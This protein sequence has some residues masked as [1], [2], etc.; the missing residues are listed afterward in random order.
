M[1]DA[2]FAVSRRNLV[3]GAAAAAASAAFASGIGTA[4]ADEA[5]AANRVCQI[6]GIE[7]PVVQA[8]M[9]GLTSPELSAAVSEAGGL[10]VLELPT[11]ETIRATKALT[12]KPF[13]AAEYYYDDET[14]AML[15]EEGVDIVV[16]CSAAAIPCEANGY[17]HDYESISAYKQAGFT[18]IFKDLNATPE[19]TVAAVEAGADI[20]AVIGFG[21]GGSG[22]YV[23]ANTA[24]HIAQMKGVVE[25]P[26][27]AAGGIVNAQTAAFAACAGAEGAYVGTRFLACEEA[28]I[29]EA[30]KQVIVDTAVCEL[31]PARSAYQGADVYT[32]LTPSPLRDGI[33]EAVAQGATPDEVGAM[34][35]QA[36]AAMATGDVEANGISAG[37][38]VGM[39][40]SVL[41]AATIV[42]DI[43][44][45]FGA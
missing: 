15:K 42:D 29:P 8:C 40:D 22:P 32:Q 23:M 45:G 33:F 21:A 11:A 7:K 14:A 39:I 16:F 26:M 43:A 25:A 44:A 5:P 13:A 38:G 4:S 37:V 3:K 41:P 17:V 1:F 18:I 12:D 20:V 19:N 24:E 6:L 36:Y 10:G 30:T 28:P 35:V 2:K 31:K 9:L 34:V 27:L